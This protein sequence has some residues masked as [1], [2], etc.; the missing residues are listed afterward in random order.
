MVQHLEREIELH[1]LANTENMTLWW[2]TKS[3]WVEN[4][5]N[6]NYLKQRTLLFMRKPYTTFPELSQNQL[7]HSI[8]ENPTLGHSQSLWDK[9]QIKPWDKGLLL[10]SKL[11]KPSTWWKSPKTTARNNIPIAKPPNIPAAQ[12]PS[13]MEQ[14]E[15]TSSIRGLCRSSVPQNIGTPEG[16]QHWNICKEL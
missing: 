15:A 2:S 7:R 4:S 5:H 16:L 6:T 13:M 8:P 9:R 12:Q 10:R 14:L 11:G 3:K 1:S